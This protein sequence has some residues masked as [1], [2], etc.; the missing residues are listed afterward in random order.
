MNKRKNYLNF[1]ILYK[2]KLKNIKIV[3]LKYLY[4]KNQERKLGD[5]WHKEL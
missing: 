5:I 2:K 3:W 4:T 1:N